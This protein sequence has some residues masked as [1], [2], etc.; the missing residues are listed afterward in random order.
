MSEV[1]KMW[2]KKKEIKI[3]C[4]NCGFRIDDAVFKYEFKNNIFRCYDCA[5][6]YK[7]KILEKK[8]LKNT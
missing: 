2:F 5:K 1:I 4:N 3:Y 6:N 8:C 7:N